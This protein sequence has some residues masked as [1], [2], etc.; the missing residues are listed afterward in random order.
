MPTQ[1]ISDGRTASYNAAVTAAAQ[2]LRAGA[3]VVF[4]T[5]TVYG[6]AANAALPDA[7]RRLRALKGR[8]A[9]QPFTVHIG[10]RTDARRFAPDAPPLARRLARRIWPGPLTL[11]LEVPE[12]AAA[13]VAA[14]CPPD[15][16]R[17]IYHDGTVGLR[18][19]DHPAAR[20][21]LAEA[22]VPVVASSANAAGQ[23]PP[24]DLDDALRGLP[25]GVDYAIDGGRTQL[26]GASTIVAVK[27]DSWRVLRAGVLEERTIER[28]LRREVLFVCTGNS[29]RS[30]MAEHLFRQ[31]LAERLGVKP[32]ELAARGYRVHSAGTFAPSGAAAS[33]GAVEEM[34]RR[35]IDAGGH[36][37]QPLTREL[38]ERAERIFVMTAEHR[39][40][41]LDLAPQAAARVELLDRDG[42]VG[43]PIGGGPEAYRQCAA[44]IDRA[45]DARLKEFLHE[46][47]DWE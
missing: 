15:Q 9:A 22:G 38:A 8:A 29:C 35:G 17:E 42:P 1:I 32:D 5:E 20:Q 24:C 6:I 43:D 41:V 34:A 2:A 4:P 26:C 3:L 39:D 30:P 16:L 31:R 25:E 28:L 36:R 45:V 19:P 14:E 18:C 27:G 47:R 46:D 44:Q 33:D 40:E 10:L 37:S 23:P 11:V 7:L 21:L 12:P 13:P